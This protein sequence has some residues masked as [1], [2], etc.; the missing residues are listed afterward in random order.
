[1]TAFDLIFY[2]LALFVLFITPGPVWV[3]LIA[4]VLSYGWAGALPFAL[5]VAAGDV[6]WA[7]FA[8]FAVASVS[9]AIPVITSALSWCAA[10]FFIFLAYGLWRQQLRSIAE[11]DMGGTR[12]V[13]SGGA[14]FIEGF[15][16]GLLVIFSNPK[17][18]LFYIGIMPGFFDLSQLSL[19]DVVMVCLVSGIVP[20]CGNMGL[21]ALIVPARR[22]LSSPSAQRRVNQISAVML[23]GVAVLILAD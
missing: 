23:V 19:N 7:L 3:A 11:S 6:V 14:L 21:T 13:Y 22:L 20:F 4:R 5:A 8:V 18:I 1:M 15:V 16:S 9:H 12:R 10:G 2:A 17:A